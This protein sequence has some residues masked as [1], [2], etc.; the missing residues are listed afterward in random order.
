MNKVQFKH[1]AIQSH[2]KKLTPGA[3]DSKDLPCSHSRTQL[4]SFTSQHG[5]YTRHQKT[6]HLVTGTM[7]NCRQPLVQTSVSK[8]CFMKSS[9]TKDPDAVACRHQGLLYMY[10]AVLVRKLQSLLQDLL[11]YW[12][13]R[14]C[15]SI[16]SSCFTACSAA[17]RHDWSWALQA[18]RSIVTSAGLRFI[19]S[20]FMARK[21]A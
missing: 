21:S 6:K 18:C 4:F 11:D 3:K 10:Y 15:R 17:S 14:S 7:P 20:S 13:E 12:A 5:K 8:L 19:K 9:I 1:A 16:S 2:I